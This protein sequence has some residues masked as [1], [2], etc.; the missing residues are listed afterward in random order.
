MR[1]TERATLVYRITPTTNPNIT[2]P[3][4]QLQQKPLRR[5][6]NRSIHQIQ[7]IPLRIIKRRSKRRLPSP[8]TRSQRRCGDLSP[9]EIQA[10]NAGGRC[11]GGEEGEEG[12]REECVSKEGCHVSSACRGRGGRLFYSRERGIQVKKGESRYVVVQRTLR[13]E[14]QSQLERK[15][16]GTSFKAGY[17]TASLLA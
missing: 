6:P 1:E 4:I 8:Q 3:S 13:H 12:E 17:T 5:R 10:E 7:Q 11:G 15:Q 16:K 14:A 2:T 9:L